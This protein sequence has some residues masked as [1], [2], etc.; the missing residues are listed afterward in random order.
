[1]SEIQVSKPWKYHYSDV[2]I[3]GI[4]SQITSL[5]IVYSALY[6]GADQRKHQNSTSLA[7]VW[8]IPRWSVNS[9]HKGP[10]TRK[11]FLFDDVIMDNNGKAHTSHLMMMTRWVTKISARWVSCTHWTPLHK[12]NCKEDKDNLENELH[13]RHAL[14]RVYPTRIYS[15]LWIL[16][17]STHMRA[18][19]WWW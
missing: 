16:H 14:D 1:M 3:G 9:P 6:S 10:V 15:P 11:M 12:L 2:I 17:R 4:A 19:A 18:S 5:T 13:L 8:G 7:F